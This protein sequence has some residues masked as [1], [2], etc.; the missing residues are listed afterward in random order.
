M[1]VFS[2]EFHEEIPRKMIFDKR[3]EGSKKIC[4]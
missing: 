2:V 4:N 1:R 3:T